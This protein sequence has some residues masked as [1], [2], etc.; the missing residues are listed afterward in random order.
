MC[1]VY[2]EGERGLSPH[3]LKGKRGT[4]N[5][6]GVGTVEE[7][8]PML[9]LFERQGSNLLSLGLRRSFSDRWECG[10]QR[11]EMPAGGT[12]HSVQSLSEST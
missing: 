10:L 7:V 6:Q 5:F 2:V 3:F 4:M 12:E 8:A 11:R 1:V 9:R